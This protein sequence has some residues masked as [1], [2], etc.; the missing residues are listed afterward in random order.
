MPKDH[1]TKV[2]HQP[3]RKF[4]Q[5]HPGSGS[6]LSPTIQQFCQQEVIYHS[7]LLT[8]LLGLPRQIGRRIEIHK[9]ANQLE[10]RKCLWKLK[11]WKISNGYYPC[12]LI[13]CYGHFEFLSFVGIFNILNS[14]KTR[15]WDQCD[16]ISVKRQAEI[17]RTKQVWEEPKIVPK[18]QDLL[19]LTSH[20]PPSFLC[21]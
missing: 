5:H 15:M 18:Y 14:L 8:G 10:K 21:C 9:K 7:S 12:F 6:L 20:A 2:F 1:Q 16:S 17:Y 4:L 19:H 13:Q 3:D 11:R